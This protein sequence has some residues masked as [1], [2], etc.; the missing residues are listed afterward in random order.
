MSKLFG[1]TNKIKYVCCIATY[2]NKDGNLILGYVYTSYKVL[3]YPTKTFCFVNNDFYHS[4]I[5]PHHH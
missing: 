5:Q 1:N 4:H 2:S 3:V